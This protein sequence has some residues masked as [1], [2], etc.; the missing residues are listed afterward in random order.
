M[1]L[2]L[3][4]KEANKTSTSETFAHLISAI[5]LLIRSSPI[6]KPIVNKNI[7]SQ[8]R[9]QTRY[10]Y[11]ILLQGREEDGQVIQLTEKQRTRHIHGNLQQEELS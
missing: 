1:I 8:P 3:Q 5:V 10:E 9:G 11:I 7:P 6:A 2:G 4:E